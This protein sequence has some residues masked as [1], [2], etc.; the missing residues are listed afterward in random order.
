MSPF[1]RCTVLNSTGQMLLICPVKC[2]LTSG[3]FNL[4]NVSKEDYITIECMTRGQSLSDHWAVAR[5]ERI[6]ASNFGQVCKL[7]VSTKPDTTLKTIMGYHSFHNLHTLYGK[8][9]ESTALDIY[10]N[11]MRKNIVDWLLGNVDCW[12]PWN[13]PILVLMASSTAP[14]VQTIMGWLK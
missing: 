3:Y 8:K 6:T 2:A 13:T 5:E 7:Q 11:Y 12:W 14:I 9:Q 1:Q 10:G 4:L